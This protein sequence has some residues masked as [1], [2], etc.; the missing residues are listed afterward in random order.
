MKDEDMTKQQLV[1]E[2]VRMRQRIAELE[3]EEKRVEEALNERVR[4]LQCLYSIAGVAARPGIT[5]DELYQEVVDLLPLI[6]QYP[7][8]TC[9]RITINGREFKTENCRDTMWRQ[10]SDIKVHGVKVGTVETG[11]LGE[12]PELDEGL[13]SREGGMLLD[14]VAERL[15]RITERKRAE[16]ALRESEGFSSSLL[17]E[18]PNPILVINPDASVRYVNPALEKLTGFSSEELI[19]TKAPYPWWGEDMIEQYD[20]DFNKAMNGWLKRVEYLFR[21]KDGRRFWVRITSVPVRQDGEFKYYLS[22]WVDITKHKQAEEALRESEGFSSRLLSESPNPVLVLNLDAS[23]RYVNPALEKLTGFSSKE[24][25][26]KKPPYPWWPE[27]TTGQL[28][29]DFNTAMYGGLRG[30]EL[31]FKRKDGKRLWVRIISVPVRQDGEFKYYL[32]NWVDITEYKQAEKALRESE[33]FGSSLLSSAPNPILVI[34]PDTSLRYVNPALEKLTGFSSEEIIGKKAPYPWWSEE[35]L[36]KNGRNFEEAMRNGLKKVEG[37]FRRKNG[38]R[39]WAE[40]SSTPI[41]RNGELKYFL[42]NSV[43]ITERKRA[44]AERRELERKAELQSRLASIGQ[45]ASGI[46]HEIN[47]PLTGVIGFS[48]LLVKKDLPE[49]IR[50]MVNV[51]NDGAQRVAGIVKRLL[52]F[53]RQYK[54]ERGYINVNDVL[55]TALAMRAYELKTSNIELDIR[56][57]ANLPSTLA[58]AGQLQQVFLNII[59]NAE[60]EMNKAYG[61]GNLLIK[62]GTVGDAIRISFK[63]NGPGIAKKDLAKIF[64]PFFTTRKIGEG[65]GLGLSICHGIVSEHNGRI[66]A[67]SRLGQGATFIVELPVVAEAEQVEPAEPS[68]VEFK[69]VDG[70]KVL[71]VDDEPA[72]L[73]VMN[74]VLTGEGYKVDTVDNAKD[75]LK[76]IVSRR[77]SLVLLDIKMPGMS[78]IEL[79]QHIQRMLQPLAKRVVFMTGDVIGDDTREFLLKTKI[80]YITKPFSD[81]QLRQDINRI[82]AERHRVDKIGAD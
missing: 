74:Q 1:S 26:G 27:E 9:A 45:M 69:R 39:F 75:A 33:E 29:K 14:A 3:D 63:D 81:E 65:T 36:W 23:V 73:G 77:Y 11:Y 60:L 44:E 30:I 19:G 82:L 43:D 67:R 71:V 7:V 57:D 64:D 35:T 31:L 37:A 61:Q 80:P 17:N 24:L 21:G 72:V 34:N 8:I 56:L 49:D 79:Y 48:Q 5:L 32:S 42:A 15:G 41:I 13:F 4:E 12:R 78:G 38:V 2:L 59:I 25:V 76:R 70:V 58:D 66:Y 16:E 20:G 6:W 46:A 22:N 52:I 53:A 47:N 40:I 28:H 62:T 68:T 10:S 54:P 51:V 18:S 50:Q 55:E